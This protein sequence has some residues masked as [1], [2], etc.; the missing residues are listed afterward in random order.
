VQCLTS[1]IFVA[2][3]P[4]TM[5]RNGV[6]LWIPGDLQEDIDRLASEFD[7]S[8]TQIMKDFKL[9]IP[10]LREMYKRRS[11]ITVNVAVTA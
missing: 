8:R 7:L 10:A 4:A 3:H 6:S 5:K 1:R 2:Y 11:E 9:M